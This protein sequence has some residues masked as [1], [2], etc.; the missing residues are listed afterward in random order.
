MH[1]V[2]KIKSCYDTVETCQGAVL[3]KIVAVTVTMRHQ[4]HFIGLYMYN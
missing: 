3:L 1:R 2:I 4:D